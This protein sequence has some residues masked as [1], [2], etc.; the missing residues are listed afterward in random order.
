M[1]IDRQGL[2]DAGVKYIYQLD[3]FPRTSVENQISLELD[4]ILELNQ[5]EV[6]NSRL[7]WVGIGEDS[8]YLNRWI[9]T[10]EG[11]VLAGIRHFSGNREKPFVYFWP[12][13]KIKSISD[14]I[15]S[16]EPHFEI[17]NPKHYHF[18]C[19]PDCNHSEAAVIQ[20][21]FISRIK[22]MKENHSVLEKASNYYDWYSSEYHEF[23][24]ENPEYVDRIPMNSQELMDHC[25]DQG[26]LYFLIEEGR[27]VGLIA[28]EN[29]V[30]LGQPAVYLN[31]ILV[32][33]EY[34]KKGYAKKLLGSFVNLLNA[35]YFLCH[36]DIDNIPSTKTALWSGQKVFSQ[37]CSIAVG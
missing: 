7:N 17:F 2:V 22:N 4:E 6:L 18:W 11:Y 9:E 8:D 35:E 32:A 23:H 20:Q 24:K 10:S 25:L 28:G 3:D 26:L 29:E 5:A 13:F 19:R 15:G 27:K 34:R 33:R 1:K 16:I 14:V 12:S 37:E 31:E 30:F 36:I 21:R